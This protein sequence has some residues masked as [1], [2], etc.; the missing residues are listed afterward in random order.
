MKPENEGLKIIPILPIQ[1]AVW[2]H[3]YAAI[4]SLGILTPG[5][6]MLFD[7][8][9]PV[10]LEITSIVPNAGRVGDELTVNYDVMIDRDGCNGELLRVIIDS[11]NHVSAFVREPIVFTNRIGNFGERVHLSKTFVIPRGVTPGPAI[12]APLIDRWCNPLQRYLWPIQQDPPPRGHFI[13]LE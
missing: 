12:Y 7:R 5:A 10:Q 1:R 13:M 4:F 8:R 11:A 6:I 9:Q 2:C 3:I